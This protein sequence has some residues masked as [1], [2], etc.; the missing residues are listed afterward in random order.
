MTTYTPIS[1]AALNVK[2]SAID[3]KLAEFEAEKSRLAFRAAS[4]DGAAVA[5]LDEI[6]QQAAKEE[7]DRGVLESARAEALRLEEEARDLAK[8]QE[9]QG[10]LDAAADAALKLREKA[11]LID[12]MVEDFAAVVGD[13]ND[14]ERAVRTECSAARVSHSGVVGQTNIAAIATALFE[15]RFDPL[16]GQQKTLVERMDIA[17]RH[18]PKYAKKSGTGR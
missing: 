11:A 14:L 5:R 2:I 15:S 1:S 18:L 12:A 10:H 13:I 4:G 9:R 17:W 6:R 8:E 3:N 16:R 7:Y